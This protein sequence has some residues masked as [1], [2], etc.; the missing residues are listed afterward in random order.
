MGNAFLDITARVGDYLI[1]V[2]EYS[3]ATPDPT[4][5]KALLLKQV[6]ALQSDS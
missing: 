6:E 3:A 5:A 2:R 1:D 4:A